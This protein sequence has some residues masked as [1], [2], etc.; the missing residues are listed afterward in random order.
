MAE[1]L[2]ER[3]TATLSADHN[4]LYL[5]A[6]SSR[7][8]IARFSQGPFRAR[9][10]LRKFK[11]RSERSQR[12]STKGLRRWPSRVHLCDG[13]HLHRRER[14]CVGCCGSSRISRRKTSRRFERTVLR[15]LGSIRLR[16]Q[17]D[18]FRHQS[19]V[20][21]ACALRYS[22]NVCC[23]RFRRGRVSMHAHVSRK[24]H[25]RS[26]AVALYRS[27]E[28]LSYFICVKFASAWV[29]AT[30]SRGSYDIVNESPITS[31]KSV[32]PTA[33]L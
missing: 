14:H 18:R 21:P 32:S 5:R 28:V 20:L 24:R 15:L 7:T 31:A 17:G 23:V 25:S 1:L 19:L 8:S 27:K 11:L 2:L 26:E 30:G 6:P 3:C 12:S 29:A 22:A 13:A 10:R 9:V 16:D 4:Q 33:L